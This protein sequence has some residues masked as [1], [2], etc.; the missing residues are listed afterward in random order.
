VID[1]PEKPRLP[2]TVNYAGGPVREARPAFED[3]DQFGGRR[4]ALAD[5]QL[6]KVARSFSKHIGA[7]QNFWNVW[8]TA[9]GYV[10]VQPT[11]ARCWAE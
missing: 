4:K 9:S 3:E 7:W 1:W 8:R 5:T 10:G 6:V 11:V 2:W